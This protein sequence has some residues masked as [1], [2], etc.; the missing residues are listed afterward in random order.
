MINETALSNILYII[1]NSKITSILPSLASQLELLEHTEKHNSNAINKDIPK[2][3]LEHFNN[4]YLQSFKSKHQMCIYPVLDN[5]IH[6]ALA[7]HRIKHQLRDL[8]EPYETITDSSIKCERHPNNPK[9]LRITGFLEYCTDFN[10]HSE[11]E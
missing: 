8:L 9:I 4:G 5:P 10:T 2:E 11:K 7:H 1:K 6:I 3:L